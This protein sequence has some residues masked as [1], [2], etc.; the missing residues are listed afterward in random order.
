MA[1]L[2]QVLQAASPFWDDLTKTAAAY[3]L[4]LPNLIAQ[5]WTESRFKPNAV[6][7]V[8]ATG[9]SQ[10]MPGTAKD[11]GLTNPNDPSASI[12]AQGRLMRDLLAKNNND[13]VLANAAYNAGQGNV[14]KYG[15]VPP[16]KETQKYT[17]QIQD[18]ANSLRA[19]AGGAPTSTPA[20]AVS[21]QNGVAPEAAVNKFELPPTKGRGANI[22]AA[23]LSGLGLLGGTAANVIGGIKGTGAVGNEAIRGSTS[24]LENLSK[25]QQAE[26][27]KQNIVDYLNNSSLDPKI[28]Q[29]AFSYVKANK[30]DEAIKLINAP[31]EAQQKINAVV[32]EKRAIA[33]DPVLKN[34]EKEKKIAEL[35]QYKAKQEYEQKLKENLVVFTQKL[36]SNDPKE[37]AKATTD[38]RKEINQAPITKNTDEINS[39]ASRAK[40]AWES[41]LKDPKSKESK[42]AL[43]Q[44]LIYV[45][46]KAN[47]TGSA[48]REGEFARTVMGVPIF[49]KLQG[50]AESFKKGGLSLT[51]TDRKDLV[52]AIGLMQKAQADQYKEFLTPYSNTINEAGY[53]SSKIL[54]PGRGDYIPIGNAGQP[55]SKNA[56]TGDSVIDFANTIPGVVIRKK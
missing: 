44:T 16:F 14:N 54:V 17:Q 24:L 27:T 4:D 21:A 33:T 9:I 37:I 2:S 50:Y 13:Y 56:K 22:A 20:E 53:D 35:D 7:P 43:D 32:A 49:N 46:N 28:K 47:D 1:D 29:A 38:L 52:E 26:Y 51:D 55:Q 31:I 8:G 34:E 42:N 15:G 5:T 19:V 36:K 18:I 11:Y 45:F 25:L 41:Y 30:P 23:V 3:N 40:S 6:S 48:V 12:D 39:F 10:F